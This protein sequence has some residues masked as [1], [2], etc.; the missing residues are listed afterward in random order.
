MSHTTVI[1]K[2]FD[3][4]FPTRTFSPAKINC[5]WVSHLILLMAEILHRLICSLCH[6]LQCLYIP[7]GAGFH[8][9]TVRLEPGKRFEFR[10]AIPEQKI[11][12]A[13]VGRASYGSPGSK[14][15]QKLVTTI[16][17]TEAKFEQSFPDSFLKLT[18]K[19]EVCK[20]VSFKCWL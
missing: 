14:V 8:P 1:S 17:S 11:I 15:P 12:F 4:I 3:Q 19:G 5:F 7:S 20:Y 10:N 13:S 2:D 18:L 9:S 16:L 6:Y